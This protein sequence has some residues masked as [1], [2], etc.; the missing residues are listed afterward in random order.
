MGERIYFLFVEALVHGAAGAFAAWFCSLF[1]SVGTA[2]WIVAPLSLIGGGLAAAPVA[3]F[4][5]ATYG[6]Y[7]PHP[8]AIIGGCFAGAIGAVVYTQEVMLGYRVVD[9]GAAVG[10]VTMA[11]ARAYA[12]FEN[13]PDD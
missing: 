10:L 11:G 4:R 5:G 2:W 7:E 3:F 9:W 8:S 6:D 13:S 1:F 12:G